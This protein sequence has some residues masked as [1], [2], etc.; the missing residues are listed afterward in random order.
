MSAPCGALDP[1]LHARERQIKMKKSKTREVDAAEAIRE[2][3]KHD[4]NKSVHID[5]VVKDRDLD[6]E[7]DKIMNMSICEFAEYALKRTYGGKSSM[8][9]RDRI[10]TMKRVVGRAIELMHR[11]GVKDLSIRIKGDIIDMSF[12]CEADNISL[13]GFMRPYSNTRKSRKKVSVDIK[14]L[15]V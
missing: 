7:Y 3:E 8:S 5:K 13:A 14:D 4:T 10:E 2:I 1:P 6:G 9:S 11:N 12:K 15:I